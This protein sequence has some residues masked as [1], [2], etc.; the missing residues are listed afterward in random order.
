MLKYMFLPPI[1]PTT[2][3]GGK[4]I[5]TRPWRDLLDYHKINK[6]VCYRFTSYRLNKDLCYRFTRYTDDY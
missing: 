5:M 1:S 6:D 2:V 4:T 3:G